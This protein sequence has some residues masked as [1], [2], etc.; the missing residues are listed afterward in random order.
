[1]DSITINM[2]AA[3]P[4]YV[5]VLIHGTFAKYAPWINPEGKFAK[6]LMRLLNTSCVAY[7]FNWSGENSHKERRE[8]G[9]SLATFLLQKHQMHPKSEIIIIAHSH[10]G[11]VAL[12]A[13]KKLVCP[14][15]HFRLVTLATPFL[16]FTLRDL[17]VLYKYLPYFTW[18]LAFV[19]LLFVFFI[20]PVILISYMHNLIRPLIGPIH[21]PPTSVYFYNIIW[22]AF[23][24]SLIIDL[25]FKVNVAE[26]V[27]NIILYLIYPIGVIAN[28]TEKVYDFTKDYLESLRKKA[29]II[30]DELNT[31]GYPDFKSLSIIFKG[32]EAGIWLNSTQFFSKRIFD[33]YFLGSSIVHF[34]IKN[35]LKVFL[36]SLALVVILKIFDT[37]SSMQTNEFVIITIDTL[38]KFLILLYSFIICLVL[39]NYIISLMFRSNRLVFGWETFNYI[40]LFKINTTPKPMH[41]KSNKL[42]THK[43]NLMKL[44]FTLRHSLVYDNPQIIYEIASWIKEDY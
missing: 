15:F 21:L 8:G 42:I 43:I 10:G 44:R 16:S 6:A 20:P 19:L 28:W 31:N 38:F 5:L 23:I 24:F 30:L 17:K 26:K 7:D 34:L 37:I 41:L 25:L 27:W 4:R 40:L 33:L 14:P 2:E 36:I 35:S 11:N 22:L 39:L 9:N 3:C 13:I 12:Y 32:D 1:M 29:A 18:L